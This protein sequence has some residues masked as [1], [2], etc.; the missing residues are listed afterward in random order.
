MNWA[1]Y[2]GAVISIIFSAGLGYFLAYLSRRRMS[3]RSG[4]VKFNTKD[5]RK[6]MYDPEFDPMPILESMLVYYLQHESPW[7]IEK[8][9]VF[10]K[11]VEVEKIELK[12]QAVKVKTRKLKAKWSLV[13]AM[14][15]QIKDEIDKHILNDFK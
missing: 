11:Y 8:H 5:V 1:P 2:L 9:P 13:D 3:I 6:I 10:G 12:S 4:L 7:V 15:D 14:A